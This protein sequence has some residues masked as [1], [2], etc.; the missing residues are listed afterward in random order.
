MV[1]SWTSV[2]NGGVYS[3]ATTATLTVTA[4][5]VSMNGYQYR[6]IVT[7][8]ALCCTNIKSCNTYR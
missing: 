6:A 1:L 5:P 2:A 7:G 3:G 8:A 4:P